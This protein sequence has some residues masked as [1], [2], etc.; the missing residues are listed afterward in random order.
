MK[1]KI[2]TPIFEALASQTLYCSHTGLLEPVSQV[3]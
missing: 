3:I 2:F 1:N